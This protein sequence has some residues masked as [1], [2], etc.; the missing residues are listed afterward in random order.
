VEGK[1]SLVL[2]ILYC[3]LFLLNLYRIR[4][5]LARGGDRRR[6]RR[7]DD[8][9]DRRDRG[10]DRYDRNDRKDRNDRN[11]RNDRRGGGRERE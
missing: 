1:K 6:E 4:V 11:D 10:G 2:I 7:D 9:G 5:E 8:R 3:F